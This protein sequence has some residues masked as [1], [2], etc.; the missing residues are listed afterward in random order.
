MIQHLNRYDGPMG[1]AQR[2]IWPPDTQGTAALV[3]LWFMQ[4]PGQGLGWD[5]F[6]LGVIHLRAE[7]GVDEPVIT[8][9]GATHELTVLALQ[10]MVEITDPL[11]WRY[12]TPANVQV[13]FKARTDNHARNL[14]AECAWA[15][16]VGHL[17]A[18]TQVYVTSGKHAGKMAYA[19]ELVEAWHAAVAAT[20]NHHL[21]GGH[22]G[23]LN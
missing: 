5:K 19:K 6:M 2:V 12:L 15:C 20:A 18:E 7:H 3:D 11:P 17:I 10:E 22:H 9:K 21:T 23:T 13:Q 4:L 16:T 14:G 1:S 8:T